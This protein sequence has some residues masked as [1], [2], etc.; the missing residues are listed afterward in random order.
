MIRQMTYG[1]DLEELSFGATMALRLAARAGH[2]SR[3][4]PHQARVNTEM[5][6]WVWGQRSRRVP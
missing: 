6:L 2:L 1:C 5:E 4:L 3:A